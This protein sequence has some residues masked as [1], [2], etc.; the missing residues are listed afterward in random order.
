MKLLVHQ[1][2][3]MGQHIRVCEDAQE[4]INVIETVDARI[5]TLTDEAFNKLKDEVGILAYIKTGNFVSATAL[6][7]QA[8]M[9]SQGE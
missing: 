9:R 7:N 4:A 6:L 3:F 1:P 5:F 2:I 8:R